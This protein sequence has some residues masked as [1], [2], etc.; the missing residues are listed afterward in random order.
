MVLN[1]SFWSWWGKFM[2]VSENQKTVSTPTKYCDSR[3]Q[4]LGTI[5]LVLCT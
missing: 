3:L 2:G 4:M 1:N 5:Y